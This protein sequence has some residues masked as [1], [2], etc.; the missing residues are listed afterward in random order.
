MRRYEEPYYGKRYLYDIEKKTLHDLLNETEECNIDSID[1]EAID[2][3]SSLNEASLLLDHPFY[4][5]CPHC[6]NK[7]EK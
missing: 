6:M 7:E 1:K 5:P 4:Y 2:M 3:Y